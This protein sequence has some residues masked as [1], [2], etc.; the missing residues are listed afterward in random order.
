MPYYSDY[1]TF[2]ANN[3]YCIL[4][5]PVMLLSLW[6][7]YQVSSAFRK[8]SERPND[9]GIT[10]ADAAKAVLEAHGIKDVPVFRIEGS[11]TDHFDPRENSINLSEDVYR[12]ATIAA[13]GVA[14]HEAGHAVQYA[15]GYFF[16]RV[17]SALLPATQFGSKFSFV[18]LVAGM[19]LY[20]QS[21]LFAG[22]IAFSLTTAFTLITLPIELNASRRALDAIESGWL[23]D[24]DEI[25]CARQILRAAALT[26]VASLL[27]S[28]LELLRYVLL[29]AARS[30]GNNRR[31]GGGR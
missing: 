28:V 22:I 27:M 4:L 30:G 9:R 2:L 18:L 12:A 6:A 11:L 14:A 24:E 26:Y 23:L 16:A 5:I 13:V 25:G 29:F 3:I 19:L 21:L 15:E 10:G 8:Y 7:Q 17:R 31:R 1:G 20:S